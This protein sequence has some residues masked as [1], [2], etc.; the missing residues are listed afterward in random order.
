MVPLMKADM[1]AKGQPVEFP[2]SNDS[3]IP[4]TGW[5]PRKWFDAKT[6]ELKFWVIYL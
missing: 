5:K 4:G 3:R 1:A 6:G 2:K